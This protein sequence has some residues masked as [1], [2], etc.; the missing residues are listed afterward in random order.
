[1]AERLAEYARRHAGLWA[2]PAYALCGWPI[3]FLPAPS[4]Q[5]LFPVDWRN[6]SI[7]LVERRRYPVAVPWLL[8]Y[9]I[10]F[11][12]DGN[13][14]ELAAAGG[15]TAVELHRAAH[16]HRSSVDERTAAAWLTTWR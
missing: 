10:S 2:D 12:I 5:P 6:S 8:V 3:T 13:I 16:Q 4:H 14:D 15:M 7:P 1:M 9:G 11:W